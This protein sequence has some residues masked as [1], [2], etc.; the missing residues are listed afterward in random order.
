MQAAGTQYFTTAFCMIIRPRPLMPIRPL[1]IKPSRYL[2]K[3]FCIK[4]EHFYFLCYV[5]S[6]SFMAGGVRCR[7]QPEKQLLKG[8]CKR[9]IQH[10]SRL[11]VFPEGPSTDFILSKGLYISEKRRAFS[12][13][14]EH[15]SK[16]VMLNQHAIPA[17]Q[18]RRQAFLL[19]ENIHQLQGYSCYGVFSS[20]WLRCDPA[21]LQARFR[22][23][24]FREGSPWF[25]GSSHLGFRL[26]QGFP[27]ASS[28]CSTSFRCKS[29]IRF[30]RCHC[31]VHVGL[32]G[33][34]EKHPG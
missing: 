14:M 9:F 19:F 12:K 15:M 33:V 20:D 3:C 2:C 1:G 32:G 6:M 13:K 24:F 25:P 23:R 26:P 30:R 17:V 5:H 11:T 21:Q 28:L 18:V 31:R 29:Q 4:P 27:T 34:S 7:N 10:F 16:D 22:R 8:H